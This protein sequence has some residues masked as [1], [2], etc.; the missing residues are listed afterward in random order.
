[1]LARTAVGA[2]RQPQASVDEEQEPRV[3]Y[4]DDSDQLPPL[5]DFGPRD[6]RHGVDRDED[7]D[8]Y[9][10]YRMGGS[11]GVG[12]LTVSIEDAKRHLGM[13]IM[14]IEMG[15]EVLLSR[16]G[17]VVAR[18]APPRG[19]RRKGSGATSAKALST[20]PVPRRVR[21]HRPAAVPNEHE[22]Y[23]ELPDPGPRDGRHGVD[24]DKG[25]EPF[26]G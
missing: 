20:T 21:N 18:L 26:S 24:R 16:N 15:D 8:P 22:D 23:P 19:T 7:Y 3:Y 12:A 14:R 11:T 5:P 25:F 17:V 4:N 2:Y 9:P 13:L 6:G 10:P 1:M